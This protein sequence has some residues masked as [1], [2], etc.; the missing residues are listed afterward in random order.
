MRPT[1]V[2][3]QP[4]GDWDSASG[5]SR[6]P[7]A[8]LF[9]RP[10][11][12]FRRVHV[13]R[14]SGPERSMGD[15]WAMGGRP[16]GRPAGL[17]PLG[18]MAGLG[19]RLAA[20]TA[21]QDQPSFASVPAVSVF[22]VRCAVR[23]PPLL[24]SGC[25]APALPLSQGG[26]GLHERSILRRPTSNSLVLAK[27]DP[28]RCTVGPMSAQVRFWSGQFVAILPLRAWNLANM[29]RACRGVVLGGCYKS[30]R[31]SIACR[32]CSV[33]VLVA[34]LCEVRSIRRRRPTTVGRSSQSAFPAS[35]AAQARTG[36]RQGQ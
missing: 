35:V 29:G 34:R 11:V 21:Q 7:A 24:H 1:R 19:W 2:F 20:R 16:A 18:R 13:G 17:S 14:R 33:F 5:G 32:L 8:V 6:Q 10:P 36:V 27:P 12:G 30:H 9:D 26:L 3:G 25:G 4:R 22:D 15:G 28:S 23:R 31:G